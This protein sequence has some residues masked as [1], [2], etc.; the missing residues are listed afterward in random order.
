MICALTG[1]AATITKK[2]TTTMKKSK[3]GLQEG[4]GGDPPSR[5]IDARIKELGDWRGAILAHRM[6]PARF[7]DATLTIEVPDPAAA[8]KSER[9]NFFGGRGVLHP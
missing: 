6:N 1:G 8:N 2:A 3:S 7:N 4:K 9:V 5:Q